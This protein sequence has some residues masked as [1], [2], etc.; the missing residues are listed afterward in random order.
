MAQF[1][2]VLIDVQTTVMYSI[3]VTKLIRASLTGSGIDSSI[4]IIPM[5]P[6]AK[7]GE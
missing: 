7:N 1:D 6:S 5:T 3:A 2:G 4:H